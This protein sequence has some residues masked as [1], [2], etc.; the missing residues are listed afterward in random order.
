[1]NK[2]KVKILRLNNQTPLPYQ[3]TPAAAGYD[4]TAAE[5]TI[6]KSHS[7]GIVS[8]GIAL[9]LPP[10]VEAQV[11]PRSGLAFH[12]G[13]GVLNSPG[14]IDPDYRGEIKVILFNASN[15]DFSIKAGDRIAQLV[16]SR[17]LPVEFEETGHLSPTKR[18][19]GGFGHTG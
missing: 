9:E 5:D 18:N 10:G 12:H 2:I 15:Q 17:I 8:T 6:I 13:I 1:M 4:L 16:F 19:Q 3:A 7:F 14:T 11:R